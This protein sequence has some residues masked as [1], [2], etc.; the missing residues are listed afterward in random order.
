MSELGPRGPSC[1]DIS[2]PIETLHR[3]LRSLDQHYQVLSQLPS[4]S[5]SSELF[6]STQADEISACIVLQ[7]MRGK[8]P[9]SEDADSDR[10]SSSPP[11]KSQK[12]SSLG[13]K[14]VNKHG[15]SS[16]LGS[17]C[18]GSF[19][20]GRDAP[21]ITK[22]SIEAVREQLCVLTIKNKK[23]QSQMIDMRKTTVKELHG[24]MNVR[25][26]ALSQLGR[27]NIDD[28]MRKLCL[29][30]LPHRRK[31]LFSKEEE[32]VSLERLMHTHEAIIDFADKAH[33]ELGKKIEEMEERV[34]NGLDPVMSMTGK[35][36]VK[37]EKK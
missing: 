16:D 19:A 10:S 22:A 2:D 31:M 36:T 28:E 6:M 34:A 27:A 37:S 8:R 5:G 13:N 23:I 15:K 35:V 12:I 17:R 20:I 26:I 24:H 21:R 18:H 29:E 3:T 25:N 14:V 4:K 11:A 30:S 9:R 32:L 7:Q 1:H 33:E